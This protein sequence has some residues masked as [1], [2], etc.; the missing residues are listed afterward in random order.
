MLSLVSL[1]SQR[2][3]LKGV[4]QSSSGTLGTAGT[5]DSPLLLLESW[6]KRSFPDFRCMHPIPFSCKFTF[7]SLTRRH[8]Q[9]AFLGKVVWCSN[10]KSSAIG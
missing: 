10:L 2:P 4:Y 8:T 6:I 5:V 7:T 9:V 3:Y 1:L